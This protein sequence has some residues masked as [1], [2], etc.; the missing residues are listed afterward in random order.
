MS[1]Q[2]QER[3]A[4]IYAEHKKGRKFPSIAEELGISR[5]RVRQIFT[6]EDWA[7]NGPNCESWQKHFAKHPE[8]KDHWLAQYERT[9][10]KEKPEG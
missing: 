4:Y 9:Y 8:V 6:R 3:A 2:D 7:R 1:F 5:E 10:N